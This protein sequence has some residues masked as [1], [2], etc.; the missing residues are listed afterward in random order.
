MATLVLHAP[1]WKENEDGAKSFEQICSSG[2]GAGYAIPQHLRDLLHA[3]C[4]V[5]VLNKDREL[6]AEGTIV[7]LEPTGKTESGMVRYD[8]HIHNLR[9]AAY[10]PEM[11]RRTGIDVL[12]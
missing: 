8:V 7:R 3:G 4:G 6:R 10:K 12:P 1:S 11:L 9:P 2:V 5:V